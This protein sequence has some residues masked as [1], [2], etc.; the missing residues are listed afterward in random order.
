MPDHGHLQHGVDGVSH[1]TGTT[2]SD[3]SSC[4]PQAGNSLAFD[5]VPPG[6]A[7]CGDCI[8]S[9]GEECEPP[10]VTVG[11]AECGADC[12]RPPRPPED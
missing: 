4:F 1:L 5:L 10:G 6:P 8:V 12:R 3:I 2:D 9:G 7:R 11:G